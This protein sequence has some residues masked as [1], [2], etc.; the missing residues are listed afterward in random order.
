MA[1]C[2]I[3]GEGFNRSSELKL[4]KL[5]LT[6]PHK[7]DTCCKLFKKLD[8]STSHYAKHT[9]EKKPF[10]CDSFEERFISK[11]ALETH[12]RVHTGEKLYQWNFSENALP[13]QTP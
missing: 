2:D 7:C 9:G 8:K 6:E 3:C 13:N 12:W 11:S 10:Q 1:K 4:H 5:L